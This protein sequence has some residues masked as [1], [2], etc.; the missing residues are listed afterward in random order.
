[1]LYRSNKIY[2]EDSNIHGRGVFA[3]DFIKAGEI[4][5]E[6]HFIPVPQGLEYPDILKE[7]FYSWPKGGP[8]LAICL[9][10]GSIFNHSDFEFSADW[11]TDS[12][13]NKI[14]FFAL[15]DINEGEEIFINYQK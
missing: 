1:M 9:G 13:K 14:I 2:V 7:H 12:S 5:E 3:S 10:F 8:G 15:K 4:L 11:E 6:C